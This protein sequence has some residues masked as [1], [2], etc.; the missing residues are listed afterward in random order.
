MDA[1]KEYTIPIKGLGIGT[2]HFKFDLDKTFFSHFEESPILDCKLKM[3]LMLD[4][5]PEMIILEFIT[6]GTMQT[7]CDRCLEEIA[8]PLQGEHQV[9]L[10]I[11]ENAGEDDNLIVYITQALTEFNV[12]K[13]LYEFAILSIP[14][15]KIDEEGH[16]CDDEILAI[17]DRRGRDKE[18]DE[19]SNPIWDELKGFKDN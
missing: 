12:A 6:A 19:S 15:V 4:K 8:L 17:L 3:E 1:L 5:R 13:Y 9:I 18:R 14:I 10:K 11:A 16:E 2:H 7:P